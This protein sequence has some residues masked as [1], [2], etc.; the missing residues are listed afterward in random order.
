[1]QNVVS[2][3][4]VSNSETK[5][6]KMNIVRGKSDTIELKN[7]QTQIV[8][9]LADIVVLRIPSKNISE[10]Q[11]LS[12]LGYEYF[13]ADTLVYYIVDFERYQPKELRNEDISFRKA[14]L[15]DKNLLD[16]M[17]HE[18]FQGYTNHYFSNNYINKDEVLEGYAEWVSGFIEDNSKD[19]FIVYKN[20][21]AIA[22][23]TCSH[24]DGV[25]EG[26]LYG[27]MPNNSGGGIYSDIIRFTQ[28]YYIQKGFSKMK[29]S[30][31]VQNYA[32]QKVW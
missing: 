15:S 4:F 10:V 31:Q 12:K 32:V 30:T 27:V 29:V 1:M 18:I 3:Y 13:Q 25:A 16:G 11:N 8:K 28:N 6:F 26:V 7:L 22:F 17:V 5:R 2:K 23:A 24:E 20:K 19:V 9:N 21:E 14:D